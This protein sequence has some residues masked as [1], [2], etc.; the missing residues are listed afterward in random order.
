MNV[1]VMETSFDV[2]SAADGERV[3]LAMQQL[4][5]TGELVPAGGRLRVCHRF[6]SSAKKPQEVI[7]SF[8]LPRDASMRR[9]RVEGP[10]FSVESRLLPVEEATREYE[11]G[12]E[13]GSLSTLAR[14]YRDGVVNL[15]V[16]N[17]RPGEPVTVWLEILCGVELHDDG[18]R[19]RFPFTLAPS[20]HPRGRISRHD[21]AFELE[22]PENEFGDVMLPP[23][24]SEDAGLH[25]VSF[26]LFIK[27][28]ANISETGS[29]SHPVRIGS[30]DGATRV[31]LASGDVPNRDLVLDARFQPEACAIREGSDFYAMMPSRFFG[32]QPAGARRLVLL[33]DRSGSMQGKPMEQAKKSVLACLAA[34][35]E[36]DQFS[37]VAFDNVPERF[38]GRLLPATSENRDKA[39]DFMSQVE[40]RGGTELA[41][42]IDSAAEL[43]KGGGEIFVLTD[44]Q[45]FGA[46]PI[47]ERAR[48]T[49]LRLHV[50]GIGSASQDRFLASL[51]SGTGGVSRFVT[52]R[53]R[54]DMAAVDL[55]ASAG[56][57]I[58]SEVTYELSGGQI[59]PEPRRY[60]YSGTPVEIFGESGFAGEIIMRGSFGE[61][62]FA[63]P[64]PYGDG[65]TLR[66]LRGARLISE[67][68]MRAGTEEERRTQKRIAERMR[69]LSEEYGLAS[70]E[71]ALVAVVNRASDKP[72]E[73]PET[74]VVPLGVP[75]DMSMDR[76]APGGMPM[77][78]SLSAPMA[79]PPVMSQASFDTGTVP[80][81]VAKAAR[82]MRFSL[83]SPFSKGGGASG[84]ESSPLLSRRRKAERPTELEDTDP[85]MDLAARLSPD[86]GMPGD[87]RI[88]AT[89]AAL[90]AFVA[91]G[92]SVN[93]G[94]FRVHVRRMVAFLKSAQ[95]PA[96]KAGIVTLAIDAA[97]KGGPATGDW[98]AAASKPVWKTIEKLLS[99]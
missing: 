12:I 83:P 32:E 63:I 73:I 68:D 54:V 28:F 42:G 97:E 43:L 96:E 91:G 61:K 14:E 26:D 82:G 16:G 9:F 37:I 90:M 21:D 31:Q 60:V 15:A 34:L 88:A 76:V 98:T 18:F 5:L 45:V 64:P 51:A 7:Y 70:R 47:L 30:R 2:K 41:S 94:A 24:R 49:G 79:A 4:H 22:L 46:D 17:L 95:V 25:E 67:L 59:A 80:E 1:P 36:E 33:V 19:F 55:F 3:E 75:Q 44:G 20:Y 92:H 29:P 56:S 62:R 50:L 65:E 89:V 11:K 48:K 66:L 23:L 53:E 99:R 86:G 10:D 40:A 8:L 69:K 74:R 52:P 81:I 71:M 35:D 84:A 57:P 13:A 85:L 87:D 58:A 72:G 39:R 77:M 93:N 27:G 78:A 6:Q 38:A